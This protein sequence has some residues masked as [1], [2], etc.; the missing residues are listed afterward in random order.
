MT[1]YLPRLAGLPGGTQDSFGNAMES[2]GRIRHE[3]VRRY[4]AV[5]FPQTTLSQQGLNLDCR[6][7]GGIHQ[8][9]VRTHCLGDHPGEQRVVS[10]AK[11]QGVDLVGPEWHEVAF[12]HKPRNLR[13]SLTF[14][15][16]RNKQR[17]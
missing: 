6:R 1:P 8:C 7:L 17:A 9:D 14:L 4:P 12:R 15:R 3:E 11:H 16:K 5:L 2:P 10:A 13:V